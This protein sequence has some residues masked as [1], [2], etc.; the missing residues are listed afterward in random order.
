MSY[1]SYEI[2]HSEPVFA[3]KTGKGLNVVVGHIWKGDYYQE[4]DTAK[5]IKDKLIYGDVIDEI[6]RFGMVDKV[7]HCEDV[8]HVFAAYLKQGEG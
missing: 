3:A 6:H 5:E 7:I 4:I 2:R 8:D 1:L